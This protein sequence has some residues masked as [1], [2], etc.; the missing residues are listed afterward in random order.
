[1]YLLLLHW[2]YN[3]LFCLIL[4]FCNTC[5][6]VNPNDVKVVGSKVVF[7]TGCKSAKCVADLK[8]TS[9]LSDVQ[10]YAMYNNADNIFLCNI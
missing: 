3:N 4:D 2:F 9:H 8:I 10:R 7:S 1:M 5:V 6:A